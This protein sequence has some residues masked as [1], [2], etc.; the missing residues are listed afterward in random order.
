M[1]EADQVFHLYGPKRDGGLTE[2][3]Y[4]YKFPFLMLN[5]YEWGSSIATVEPLAAGRMR[6]VNWYFFTDVSSERAEANRESAE[7][8]ARIVSEDIDMVL[9]VQRNL[10]A[11]VYTNGILSPQREHAVAAFQ[12]MVRTALAGTP[13]A[14]LPRAAP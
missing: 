13:Q 12:A 11:G 10:N 8:S 9:G 1:H 6:H 7:W 14:A 2:G 5:L 4:F 3:L